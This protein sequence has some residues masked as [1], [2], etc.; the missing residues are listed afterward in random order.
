M[1]VAYIYIIID[2][3]KSFDF[4]LDNKNRKQDFLQ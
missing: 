1:R 3:Y 4:Y 2:D